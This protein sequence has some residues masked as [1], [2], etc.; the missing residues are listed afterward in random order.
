MNQISQIIIGVIIFLMVLMLSKKILTWKSLNAFRFIIR[1]LKAKG[2]LD[3]A[4]AV[5]LHYA[6]R[7]LLRL[8]FRDYRPKILVQMIHGQIIGITEEGKYFLNE[9]NLP[10]QHQMTSIDR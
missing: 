7:N 6:K 4:S 3:A 8:G 2:A 1:D 5:E 9:A 10:P